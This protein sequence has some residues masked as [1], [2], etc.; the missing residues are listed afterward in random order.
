MKE[1]EKDNKVSWGTLKE[2]ASNSSSVEVRKFYGGTENFHLSGKLVID[3]NFLPKADEPDQ[4]ILRRIKLLRFR[5]MMTEEEKDQRI[6]NYIVENELPGVLAWIIEGARKW[7]ESGL[8]NPAFID[9]ELSTYKTSMDTH[10]AITWLEQ[11]GYEVVHNKA[12]LLPEKWIH[13]TALH[14]DYK[15]FA[16]EGGV[17]PYGIQEF[18]TFLENRGARKDQKSRTIE[19]KKE[20]AMF[21]L[22]IDHDSAAALG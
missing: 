15:R 8:G 16:D 2:L 5:H 7:Y 12:Q 18:S 10:L 9:E 11:S 1:L 4:S 19:G 14:A 17:K 22:N 13:T 6:F 21:W 20:R 3:T